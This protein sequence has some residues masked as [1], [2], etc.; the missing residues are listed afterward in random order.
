MI[1]MF[2][3]GSCQSGQGGVAFVV[4]TNDGEV[5][6]EYHNFIGPA[7]NNVAEYVALLAAL[8]WCLANGADVVNIY[9]DSELLVRHMSGEYNVKAHHLLHLAY[10]IKAKIDNLKSVTISHI[11]REDNELADLLAKRAVEI[12]QPYMKYF[13][14][15]RLRMEIADANSST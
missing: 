1:N 14:R 3:D 11:H 10:Q 9:S 2:L 8:D 6:C 12:R 4:K 5:L 15:K 7:T 13:N